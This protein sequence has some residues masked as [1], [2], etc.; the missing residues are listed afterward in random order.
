MM[1]RSDNGRD[2]VHPFVVAVGAVLMGGLMLLGTLSHNR[3]ML[4]PLDVRET[5]L[6]A[7]SGVLGGAVGG[8]VHW[9]L[10][11]WAQG[12]RLRDVLRWQLAS[13]V[14]TLP[15]AFVAAWAYHL[16][17]SPLLWIGFGLVLGFS[18]AMLAEYAARAD[19]ED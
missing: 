18:G 11:A 7:L 3:R 10:F 5:L 13:L 1:D 12:S 16:A 8:H 2:R 6:I 19:A 15:P 9:R 4:E 17:I 14:A